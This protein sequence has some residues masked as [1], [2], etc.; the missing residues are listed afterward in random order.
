MII[1]TILGALVGVL[2]GLG[3]DGLM[4]GLHSRSSMVIAW[5]LTGALAGVAG[6]YLVGPRSFL[7]VVLT[8]LVGAMA[9]AFASRA[10][11]SSSLDRQ[12]R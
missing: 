6:R 7:I 11:I 4:R 8:A 2:A 1:A 12:P 3:I 9:F 5:S 10:R